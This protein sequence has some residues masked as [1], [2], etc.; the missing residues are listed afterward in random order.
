MLHRLRSLTF[1]L[2]LS[3]TALFAQAPEAHRITGQI[4]GLKDATCYLAHFFGPTQ[5]TP[6]DTAKT[7][8]EGRV[9]FTGTK[10]LPEGL[11]MIVVDAKP[12]LQLVIGEQQFAFE[13]DT[14]DVVSRMRVT[15]SREN[16]LFY[17]YQQY[18]RQKYEEMNVIQGKARLQQDP[19]VPT[20]IAALQKEAADFRRN[21]L[22]KNKGTL[23]VK[24]LEAAADPE[25]PPLPRRA[26]GSVDSTRLFQ[27]YKARFFDNLDFSDDRLIRTPFLQQKIDRYIKELTVQSADSL[28]KEA[29]F[30]I[31]KA[32][33]NKEVLNHTIWYITSQY[34]QPKVLGTD[35]LYVH[36]VEKYW[37]TRQIEVSDTATL[38]SLRER[39]QTLKPLLTG[40]VLPNFSVQD[41]LGRF[42]SLNDINAAY[43]V[44]FFYDPECGHCRE[45]APKL[46]QFY[47]A[48]KAKG[49][50]IF[51]VAVQNSPE[52]WNQFIREFKLQKLMNGYGPS[53]GIDYKRR[54]DVYSTPTVYVL[55]RSKKILARRLPIEDLEGYFDF[56][57]RQQKPAP[58]KPAPTKASVK[59]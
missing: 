47:E 38:T 31:G 13:T 53:A 5:Y 10:K 48:N 9:V 6:R 36:L 32:R 50:Q 25:V 44:V 35:G 21:F 33:A 30:I 34:E 54:Y 43:T 11:Y 14:A 8:A 51:A 57:Q 28:I 22:A 41:T 4:K 29:D 24:L 20:R 26:D 46:R 45:S 49:L 27:A 7:D 1:L 15:G 58:A 37:L 2:G 42:R 59:K 23:T 40:K 56:L 19:T 18:L 12:V 52:K 55:D 39:V 3:S 16:E 17:S